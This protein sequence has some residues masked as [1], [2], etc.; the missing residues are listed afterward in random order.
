MIGNRK[1]VLVSTGL[2]VGAFAGV[3]SFLSWDR[4]NQVA[5][6]VS[7]LVGVAALGISVF[8]LLAPPPGPSVR[9]SRTG[10]AVAGRGGSANTGVISVSGGVATRSVSV[11][12]TGDARADEGSANTGFRRD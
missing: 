7:A 4:A 12:D 1:A 9:V 10:K 3:L 8:A 11:V 2:A 6:V 5:G